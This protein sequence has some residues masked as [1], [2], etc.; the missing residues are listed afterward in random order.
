M[1]IEETAKCYDD[2]INEIACSDKNPPL[3]QKVEDENFPPNNYRNICGLWIPMTYAVPYQLLLKESTPNKLLKLVGPLQKKTDPCTIFDSYPFIE[4]LSPNETKY[5]ESKISEPGAP[6]TSLFKPMICATMPA[7]PKSFYFKVRGKYKNDALISYSSGHTILI[8]MITKYFKNINQLYVVI[9]LIIWLVPYNHSIH[10]ILSAAKKLDVFPE[11]DYKQSTE[12]NVMKL[13][14]K[15]NLLNPAVKDMIMGSPKIL[16][17][18]NLTRSGG[19]SKKNKKYN[20]T[21]KLSNKSRVQ[22]MRTNQR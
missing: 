22:I 13:L 21:R 2:E 17:P 4:H 6:L 16:S 1:D 11:F 10:E 19:Y 14:Q 9:A 3:Y 7:E 15:A 8:T 5:L 12:T 18:P 20:K